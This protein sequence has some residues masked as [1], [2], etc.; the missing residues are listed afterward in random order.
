MLN[1][2]IELLKSDL[3]WFDNPL[4]NM[5]DGCVERLAERLISEGVTILP[6]GAIVLTRAE[7]DALNKYADM[8]RRAD[9]EQVCI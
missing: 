2:L 6:E 9:D 7:L 5:D 8:V 4:R 3:C 1:K